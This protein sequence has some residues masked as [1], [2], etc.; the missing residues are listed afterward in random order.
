LHLYFGEFASTCLYRARQVFRFATRFRAF[1]MSSA[2]APLAF[3][4]APAPPP[5][6][7]WSNIEVV[8]VRPDHPGPALWHIVKDKSEIWIVPTVSPVPKGLPWDSE[9]I[10]SLLK[11]ANALILPPRATM[12]VFEGLWFLMTG[13]DV[14]EQPSGTTLEDTLP[15]PLKARFVATR[16]RIG[17]DADRYSEFLGG[18]AALRLEGDYW[19]F[20]N[21]TPNGPQRTIESLASRAGVTARASATYPAMNVIKDVPKM[22]AAAHL[23]CLKMALD[24]IDT[25][26]LHAVAAADA[27]AKG[28]IAGVKAHY[29]ETRLDDCLNQNAAYAALRETANR[30]MTNAIIAALAKPGTSVA[31]MPM[32]FFLRKGGVLERLE[33]AGLTVTGPG[34]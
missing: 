4:A 17:R 18:V 19:S 27:W 32:G 28:D 14:L 3:G 25:Q 20:A 16:T 2:L 26:S 1:T 7:D 23:A 6:Q 11:G 34:S 24:D 33:A 13:L 22:T 9:E 29:S 8:V 12:G 30:D 31:V 21:F 5:I 15:A 10:A